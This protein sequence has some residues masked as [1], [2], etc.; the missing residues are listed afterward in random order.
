[1]LGL[2]WYLDINEYDGP[3]SNTVLINQF[4]IGGQQIA[5]GPTN[6][7]LKR[8]LYYQ[9]GQRLTVDRFMWDINQAFLA[10]YNN[11]E[12]DTIYSVSAHLH[13]S[14][15]ETGPLL[16]DPVWLNHEMAIVY[17]FS[18]AQLNTNRRF[19]IA[20]RS[21]EHGTGYID[22][23]VLNLID[24]GFDASGANL[25]I[26]TVDTVN[27]PSS[28]A[29]LTDYSTQVAMIMDKPPVPP[30]V[31]FFPFR[32]NSTKLLL[33]LDASVG[34]LLQQPVHLT[35]ADAAAIRNQLVAQQQIILPSAPVG[36]YLEANTSVKLRYKSD[37]P[38]QKYE[39]FRSTTRPNSYA[40]FISEN[41]PHATVE[42]VIS[43][44]LTAV[45]ASYTDD[46]LPNTKYYYCV[47][48]IDIHDNFSNPG[49]VHEIELVNN[50]GQIYFTHNLVNFDRPEKRSFKKGARRYVYI[51]PALPQ[52]VYDQE[53]FMSMAGVDPDLPALDPTAPPPP[54]ILQSP[55]LNDSVW[56][57]IFKV[58]VISRKTG[59][60]FDVNITFKNS[61]VV[62]P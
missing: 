36:E 44:N 8:A 21:G 22:P 49:G 3:T 34:D 20:F 10:A 23:P 28:P 52:I 35:N 46:V 58:R 16:S 41:N 48:G 7:Q 31:L 61:G 18:G 32:G 15:I 13:S 9:D 12:T 43:S 47:R 11:G 26:A 29:I 17:H 50:A 42:E 30:D 40:D 5:D 14:A 60:K 2:Q 53:R 62:N 33:L 57:K 6:S 45:A 37:D 4:S 59:K 19:Q 38:V 54:S 24:G 27:A 51:E 39:I 56:E 1:M 25:P 55:E